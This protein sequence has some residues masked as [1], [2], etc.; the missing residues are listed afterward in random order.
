MGTDQLIPMLA[1]GTLGIALIVGVI[2]MMRFLSRRRNREADRD[3][4]MGRRPITQT[5]DT[6]PARRR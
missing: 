4:D 6:D 2:Y 3:V 5:T 1:L